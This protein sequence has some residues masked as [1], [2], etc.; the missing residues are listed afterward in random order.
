MVEDRINYLE[1]RT[2]DFTQ[3]TTRGKLWERAV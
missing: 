2:E 3:D 1:E